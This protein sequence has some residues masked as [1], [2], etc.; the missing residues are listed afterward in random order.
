MAVMRLKLYIALVDGCRGLA[1]RLGEDGVD[2]VLRVGNDR[3]ALKI[4]HAALG[5]HFFFLFEK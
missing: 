1:L 5:C 4:V 3:D 2:K